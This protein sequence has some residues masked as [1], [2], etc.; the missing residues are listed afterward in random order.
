MAKEASGGEG[1]PHS[2]SRRGSRAAPPRSR[3]PGHTFTSRVPTAHRQCRPSPAMPAD[4][5]GTWNLLSSDNLEGYMLA[6]G[7]AGGPCGGLG[8]R[9][10]VRLRAEEAGLACGSVSL[11]PLTLVRPSVRPPVCLRIRRFPRLPTPVHPPS[12]CPS[13]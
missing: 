5:S 7:R 11:S 2:S 3:L 4:L 6:L 1:S 8:L 9:P 13:V 12:R 10:R